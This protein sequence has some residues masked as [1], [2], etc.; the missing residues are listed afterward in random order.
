VKEYMCMVKNI[1]KICKEEQKLIGIIVELRG[2]K[3][4]VVNLNKTIEYKTGETVY[5]TYN[6]KKK[7][8]HHTIV[9]NS[10]DLNKMV[11]RDDNIIINDN[12]GVLIVKDIV[13][14]ETHMRKSMLRNTSEDNLLGNFNSHKFLQFRKDSN[15]IDSPKTQ[16]ST[17]EL[18]E[19]KC[20]ECLDVSTQQIYEVIEEPLSAFD[21]EN[22][23]EF[24]RKVSKEYEYRQKES[25][26]FI[27]RK[28]KMQTSKNLHARFEIK[29]EVKHDFKLTE[30]S[31]LFVP[32]KY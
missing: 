30:N 14:E 15:P 25:E 28:R 31:Y 9:M 6:T 18:E 16:R 13:E 10:K 20:S 12:Q 27:R 32:S 22:Q 4:Q 26:S 5:L 29:C 17:S 8:D 21:D 1:T 19:E 23:D 2:R 7:T 3:I 24:I 11:N